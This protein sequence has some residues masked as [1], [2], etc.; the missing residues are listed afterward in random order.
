MTD[1]SLPSFSVL[2]I[3]LREFTKSCG[4]NQL[5]NNKNKILCVRVCICA[6]VIRQGNRTFCASFMVLSVACLT[7]PYLFTLSLR[8]HNFRNKLI[9][10]KIRILI[11]CITF[12]YDISHLKRNK[13]R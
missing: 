1:K 9:E 12:V 4:I 7:V 13:A 11:F 8:Q 5:C 3:A 10:H 6:L 2:N